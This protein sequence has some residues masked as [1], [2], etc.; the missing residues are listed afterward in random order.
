MFVCP[1]HFSTAVQNIEADAFLDNV[2][3][4]EFVIQDSTD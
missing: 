1:A 2:D 3:T 4:P